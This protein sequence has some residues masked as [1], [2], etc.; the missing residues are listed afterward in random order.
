ML[1]V[2]QQHAELGAGGAGQANKTP[3]VNEDDYTATDN[4]AAAYEG[5]YN[6]CGRNSNPRPRAH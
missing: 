3:Q 1:Q 5:D 4:G 2:T 6:R